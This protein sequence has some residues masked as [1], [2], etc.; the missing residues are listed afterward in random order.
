MTAT[1]TMNNLKSRGFTLIELLTVMVIISILALISLGVQRASVQSARE[2]RTR[3]TIMKI[4]TVITSLY[5]KY[6]YRKVDVDDFNDTQLTGWTNY[7][8]LGLT[9]EQMAALLGIN[10]SDLT[11]PLREEARN[12]NRAKARMVLRTLML[13]ELLRMDMPVNYA[14]TTALS[15]YGQASALNASYQTVVNDT[16]ANAELLY[17]IVTNGD[18][19]TRTMFHDREIGDVN[20]NGLNEFLDGWGNPICFLRWAPGLAGSSRQASLTAGKTIQAVNLYHLAGNDVNNLT[21]DQVSAFETAL[22]NYL[23]LPSGDTTQLADLVTQAESDRLPAD[24]NK[25]A[26]P[27]DP[28]GLSDGWLLVP[29]VFSWGPDGE[30]GMA[31]PETLGICDNPYD[32]GFLDLGA[33]DSAAASQDNITNHNYYNE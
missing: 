10:V 29:L 14:E 5:E 17:L 9:N 13:R 27:L 3:T 6:Q 33:D 2:A 4:D 30:P 22:K 16:T 32:A 31:E 19:E 7:G 23:E 18:P 26:D 21:A 11:D 24:S 1:K 8:I 25:Y 28:L 15:A 20:D 12:L